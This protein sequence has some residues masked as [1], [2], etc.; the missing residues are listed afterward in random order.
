[1]RWTRAYRLLDVS[2]RPGTCLRDD[3]GSRHEDNFRAGVPS[4]DVEWIVV[5][6]WE[7]PGRWSTGSWLRR[8][9]G[10]IVHAPRAMSHDASRIALF[11][12]ETKRLLGEL[13]FASVAAAKEILLD[14]YRQQAKVYT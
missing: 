4:L 7:A 1:E 11:L 3:A 13:S 12:D 5:G 10:K 14:C 2:V 8:F 6:L 9:P